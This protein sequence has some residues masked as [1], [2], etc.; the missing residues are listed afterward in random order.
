[1]DVDIRFSRLSIGRSDSRERVR[2]HC[3]NNHSALPL[4]ETLTNTHP[5]RSSMHQTEWFDELLFGPCRTE[6]PARNPSSGTTISGSR[7]DVRPAPPRWYDVLEKA[8]D[9][10]TP[11]RIRYPS[12]PPQRTESIHHQQWR[13]SSRFRSSMNDR[14]IERFTDNVNEVMRCH[15]KLLLY[16]LMMRSRTKTSTCTKYNGGRTVIYIADLDL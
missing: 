4:L 6:S 2:A 16:L 8:N 15:F 14:D 10:S 13:N 12:V 5:R 7:S 3:H 11:S 1:M 9:F